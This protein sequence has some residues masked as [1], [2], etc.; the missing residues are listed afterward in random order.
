MATRANHKIEAPKTDILSAIDQIV[1]VTDIVDNAGKTDIAPITLE[2]LKDAFNTAKANFRP[3]VNKGDIVGIVDNTGKLVETGQI[4]MKPDMGANLAQV[5]W[6]STGLCG[7]VTLD[8][9]TAVGDG[10]WIVQNS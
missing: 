2:S 8:S 6:A 5:R 1:P 10:G 4:T 9:L 3:N 7:M